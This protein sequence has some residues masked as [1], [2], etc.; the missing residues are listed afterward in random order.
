MKMASCTAVYALFLTIHPGTPRRK[1]NVGTIVPG[2]DLLHW[3]RK[4]GANA[5]SLGTPA[6]AESLDQQPKTFPHE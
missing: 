1:C 3:C 2:A 6:P 4:D 5:L